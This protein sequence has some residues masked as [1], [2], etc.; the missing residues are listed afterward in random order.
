LLG[1]TRERP[2][3]P[4]EEFTRYGHRILARDSTGRVVR[5]EEIAYPVRQAKDGTLSVG[6]V[7]TGRT[8][9]YVYFTRDDRVGMP[10]LEHKPGS[11]E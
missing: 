2:K 4:A 9:G 11:P 5:A 8:F 3:A 1:W 7:P 10:I 6:Q